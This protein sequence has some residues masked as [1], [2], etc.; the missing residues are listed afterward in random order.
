LEKNGVSA[1]VESL[2]RRGVS[3]NVIVN[4]LADAKD[5]NAA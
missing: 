2:R 4:A 5:E 3:E 1:V